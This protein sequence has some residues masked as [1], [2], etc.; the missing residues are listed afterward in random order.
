MKKLHPTLQDYVNHVSGQVK[1]RE[2][3][4]DI[5]EEIAGHLEE[6][7]E[8]KLAQGL[9]DDTAAQWA[10]TQMGSTESVA[11]GLNQVHKPRIPWGM[12]SYLILLLVVALV[13]MYAIDLSYA[14]GSSRTAETSFLEKQAVFMGIGLVVLFMLSRLHYR[15]LLSMWKLIYGGA[16]VCLIAGI[17]FG[18]RVNGMPG[19]FNLGPLS[20]VNFLEVSLFAFIVS[21]AGFL[22]QREESWK[23]VFYHLVIFT[24]VP[25]FL[26]ASAH[27]FATVLQYA[28]SYLLLLCFSR[29]G[30]KW[31]L[32]HIL[33]SI[34][35]LVL[36]SF[37]SY[38]RER[39]AAFFLPYN[40]QNGAG[41]N[42]VQ[43]DEAIHSAG[44]W[45]HGFASVMNRL[46]FI[47]SDNVFTY[48]VYS[49]GWLAGAV[50]LLTVVMFIYQLIRVALSVQ[51]NY[52]KML[53]IGLG[54]LF[55]FKFTYSIG[56]SLGLLP[57]TSV[58]LPFISYGG[59]GLLV[60]LAALGI[61]YSVYR[62]KDM[63]RAR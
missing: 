40:D 57:L 13:S 11:K 58:M 7:M 9:D 62:R 63:V 38:S 35:V 12:L 18:P 46:P 4:E 28:V 10:I 56:M 61:I 1:A 30:L 52:G 24:A 25:L 44:W 27:S 60:Q 6:L 47:H 23:A 37:S 39:L 50:I 5:K 14:A 19:F 59:T 45:G 36:F 3:R 15:L 8:H 33:F 34:F 16:V 55:S 42:Y 41:Y 29:F 32:P 48:I 26:Y 20:A 31:L 43:I 51:D 49:F 54:A 2:L 17:Y 22:H 21:A 53:I